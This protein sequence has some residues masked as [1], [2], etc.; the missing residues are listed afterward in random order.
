MGSLQVA[1]VHVFAQTPANCV[2]SNHL[3][4]RVLTQFAINVILGVAD[5]ATSSFIG[6]PLHQGGMMIGAVRYQNRNSNM[7]YHIRNGECFPLRQTGDAALFRGSTH[8]HRTL[9][10]HD[11]FVVYK[12][13]FLKYSILN[14]NLSECK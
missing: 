6:H 4:L 13:V 9:S 10:P 1:D 2:F 11:G 7:P 5:L 8:V 12:L 14:L 3:G